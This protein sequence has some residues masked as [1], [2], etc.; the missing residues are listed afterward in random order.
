MP[1]IIRE[2][3]AAACGNVHAINWL[4]KFCYR[5][6]QL[7]PLPLFSALFSYSTLSKWRPVSLLVKQEKDS[8]TFSRVS[9]L[10]MLYSGKC[11]LKLHGNSLLGFFEDI[12]LVEFINFV[13]TRMPGESYRSRSKDVI[14]TQQ[15]R[16]ESATI[17]LTGTRVNTRYIHSTRCTSSS[18][19]RVQF[20][21]SLNFRPDLCPGWIQ[22]HSSIA[23]WSI[24]DNPSAQSAS[25]G[26]R[27]FYLGIR[28]NM[29]Q[30]WQGKW[31][32][33]WTTPTLYSL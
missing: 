6:H 28:V 1:Y 4:E 30:Y 26:T 27:W 13:F 8:N 7:T 5:K 29:P 15:Q 22:Q 11:K 14:Q 21:R 24:L 23:D 18:I 16:P 32:P 9:C 19:S 10:W 12:P 3:E 31:S 2:R 17:T 20:P 25:F 33:L